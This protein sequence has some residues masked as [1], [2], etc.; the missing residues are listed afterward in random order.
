MVSARPPPRVW[1]KRLSALDTVCCAISSMTERESGFEA[2]WHRGSWEEGEIALTPRE[3]GVYQLLDAAGRVTVVFGCA[4]LCDREKRP[5]I[6]EIAGELADRTVITAED[7]LTEDLDQII[8][9]IAVGCRQVGRREGADFWRIAD[10][11][12]AI[13]LAMAE[14]GNLVL[15][16]G[17]G[18]EKSICFGTTEYPWSDH[19]AVEDALV[20]R[21]AREGGP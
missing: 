17:K 21:L 14:A 8:E 4:G 2:T 20:E 1:A 9:Q 18:H 13:Q 7:P 16:S 5:I 15:V 10:R 11:G 3:M 19:Q 6:G 12:Q